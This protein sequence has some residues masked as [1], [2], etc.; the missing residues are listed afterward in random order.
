[1][2]GMLS[3]QGHHHDI[4]HKYSVIVATPQL[5]CVR[6]MVECTPIK[7][8]LVGPQPTFHLLTYPV[9]THTPPVTGNLPIE[10]LVARQWPTIPSSECWLQVSRCFSNK[11]GWYH[12]LCGFLLDLHAKPR[13]SNTSL[14]GLLIQPQIEA[15]QLPEALHVTC[16]SMA[17]LV[18]A[19]EEI[20]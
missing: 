3:C 16:N 7:V 12:V 13:Q 17:F 4:V 2:P 1:M 18:M 19:L 15:P 11:T 14:I 6:C 9:I 20:L 10:T 8:L 5:G